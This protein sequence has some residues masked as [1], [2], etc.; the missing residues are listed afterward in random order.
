MKVLKFLKKNYL[1][2]VICFA[3]IGVAIFGVIFGTRFFESKRTDLLNVNSVQDDPDEPQA[4]GNWIDEDFT[5]Y[6]LTGSGTQA[7]PYQLSTA[8]DLAFIAYQVNNGLY[9]GAVSTY[10]TYYTLTNDIDLAGKYWTPIGAASPFV[11]MSPVINGQNY[12]IKNMIIKGS[13][14]TAGFFGCIQVTKNNSIVSEISNLNFDNCYINVDGAYSSVEPSVGC[15]AGYIHSYNSGRISINNVSCSGKIIASSQNVGGL[16]G[17][18]VYLDTATNCQNHA[19]ILSTGSGTLGGFAG[20][21]SSQTKISNITNLGQIEFNYQGGG[22]I[23]VGGVCGKISGLASDLKNE[24]NIVGSGSSFYVGGISGGNFSPSNCT[25]SGDIS[26]T[27]SSFQQCFIGGIMAG[28]E[29]TTTSCLLNKNSGNIT[30]NDLYTSASSGSTYI[31]GISGY[32]NA[33]LC[34]NS[35]IINATS[36]RFSYIGGISG[37]SKKISLCSNKGSVTGIIDSENGNQVKYGSL[38]GIVGSAYGEI[39]NCFNSQ[40]VSLSVNH[41]KIKACVGGIAGSATDSTISNCY[42]TA[43]VSSTSDQT[44]SFA[45]GILGV[46][47]SGTCTLT[48]CFSLGNVTCSGSTTYSH[49]LAAQIN[50]IINCFYDSNV[51]KST[52]ISVINTCSESGSVENLANLMKQQANYGSASFATYSDGLSNGDAAWSKSWN[53]DSFW[54][55]DLSQSEYP[56]FVDVD[57]SSMQYWESEDVSS[58]SGAGTSASPYLISNAKELAFLAET[59]NAQTTLPTTLTYYKLTNDIDLTGKYWMPIGNNITDTA[60]FVGC[61]DGDGHSISGL[62]I[63]GAISYSGLFGYSRGTNATFKNFNVSGNICV[64]ESRLVYAGA[65]LG[66]AD[67][68][69]IFENIQSNVDIEVVWGNGYIGGIVGEKAISNSLTIQN[70]VNKGNLTSKTASIGGILSYFDRTYDKNHYS[71]KLIDCKN[72]GALTGGA[73]GGIVCSIATSSRTSSSVCVFHN[74]KNSGEI[75]STGTTGGIFGSFGS[76]SSTYNNF[77]NLKNSGNIYCSSSTGRVGGIFGSVYINQYTATMEI[78]E[79]LNTGSISVENSQMAYVGGIIGYADASSYNYE[80]TIKNSLNIGNVTASSTYSTKSNS[81]ASY[82]GGIVGFYNGQTLSFIHDCANHGNVTSAADGGVAYAGGIYAKDGC[83]E[84]VLG[85]VDNCYNIGA[86]SSQSTQNNSFAGGL[87]G[88]GTYSSIYDSFNIGS[89]SNSAGP[90]MT[91]YTHPISPSLSKSLNCYFDSSISASIANSSI[92]YQE[93]TG[94][95]NNL[96]NLMKNS[97]NYLNQSVPNQTIFIQNTKKNWRQ[98]WDMVGQWNFDTSISEYPIPGF[99]CLPTQNWVDYAEPYSAGDGS[100]DNPYQ[101]ST[102]EQLAYLAKQTNARQSSRYFYKLTADIDLTGK[103]WAPIGTGTYYNKSDAFYGSFDGCEH[104]ITGMRVDGEYTNAGLFGMIRASYVQKSETINGQQVTK[105]EY[106]YVKNFE[107]DKSSIIIHVHQNGSDS[108]FSNSFGLLA[109]T[110]NSEYSTVINY[111]DLISQDFEISNIKANGSVMGD[112]SYR[113]PHSAGLIGYLE[114]QYSYLKLANLHFSGKLNNAGAGIVGQAIG[115]AGGTALSNCSASF[116]ATTVYHFGGIAYSAK[117]INIS[118]CTAEGFIDVVENG[119]NSIVGGIVAK[120]ADANNNVAISHCANGANLFVRGACYN[121]QEYAGGI[122]GSAQNCTIANCINIGNIKVLSP[123]SSIMPTIAVVAGGILGHTISS[124]AIEISKCYSS[125]D[126][127]TSHWAGGIVGVAGQTN[128]TLTLSEC[129][130]S[131]NINSTTKT[132]SNS[133]CL[134]GIVAYVNCKSAGSSISD[135]YVRATINAPNISTLTWIDAVAPIVSDS[136]YFESVDNY[137]V[138]VTINGQNSTTIETK[139]YSGEFSGD[140]WFFNDNF[141]GGYPIL[142]SLFWVGAGY[143]QTDAEIKDQLDS[144]ELTEKAA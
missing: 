67:G 54:L 47:E 13:Y 133:F 128:S 142:K 79:M 104:K 140:V 86:I 6:A 137:Y 138:D 12:S 130:F 31:G 3:L 24:G 93:N 85:L 11:K 99:L 65:V 91:T 108:Y 41:P 73:C 136:Y 78:G 88:A 53:F 20:N 59:V 118:S 126:L 43:S 106:N 35:G 62:K 50:T 36:K 10:F 30:F 4:E 66:Y 8:K 111:S 21:C 14:N 119:T 124:G 125:C 100:K 144:L 56:I 114:N 9:A 49:E 134:G 45:G 29:S 63:F 107:I 116:K 87:I 48:D 1:S 75:R 17:Y 74:L 7:A 120:I 69:E 2:F 131:G 60:R 33:C 90:S 32:S 84:F 89:L 97:S 102:P 103:L 68:L 5:D 115:R 42:N 61:F 127:T 72:E 110:V 27:A 28:Y 57:T 71:L 121:S 51:T 132:Y 15:V 44:L 143:N 112:T 105:Y 16:I 141:K 70:C 22:T 64:L 76:A 117:N 83:T 52:G 26:V 94:A 80:F 82:A 25:N 39:E 98:S 46:Q 122:I 96:T 139:E 40:S 92:S 34:E 37:G 58:L 38:G 101:I 123:R 113:D 19:D 23:Y 81:Y 77:K 95:V 109:G 129:A 135:C 18:V 55:F